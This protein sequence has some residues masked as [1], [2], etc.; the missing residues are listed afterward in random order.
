MAISP[1]VNSFMQQGEQSEGPQDAEQLFRNQFSDLAYN[2]LRAKFPKLLNHVVTLKTMASDMQAG[3]SFG[4]FIIGSGDGLVYVPVAMSDG[5]ITSCE[6]AYDKKTDQFFP[7]DKNTVREIVARNL[8]TEPTLLTKNPRIEDTRAL[9]HNMIRPPSSSNVVLASSRGGVR[10]LPDSCKKAVSDY[11]TRKNPALLGKVAAFYDVEELA[12]KLSPKP[13][14]KTAAGAA[15]LPDFLR[16]DT[17]TKEAANLL[18]DDG[19]KRIL[20][21]GWLITKKAEDASM[22]VAS[23]DKFAKA[24]ETEMRLSLYTPH[25]AGHDFP[26]MEREP[27]K[28]MVQ[29]GNLLL[30]DDRGISFMPAIFCGNIVFY[31]NGRMRLACGQSALVQDLRSDDIDLSSFSMLSPLSGIK[32]KLP[33]DHSWVN[34]MAV[35][36]AR[37]NSWTCLEEVISGLAANFI[38]HDDV[39]RFTGGRGTIQTGDSLASGY[40]MLDNRNFVFPKSARFAPAGS[41]F[42]GKENP[43]PVV[44]SFDALLRLIRGFGFDISTVNDGAAIS[45]TD[46]RSEKTASFR[47]PADAANYLY[48]RYN[49]SGPQIDEVLANKKSTV[50]MKTAYM[51]PTP[52]DVAMIQQG[53]YP[54]GAPEENPMM[55]EMQQQQPPRNF[56]DLDDFAELEDPEMF[57]VGIL[58]AFAQKP[59]IKSLLVEYLPDFLAAED[60]IGR[61]LLLF[62]SQKKEIEDFY[63]PEKAQTVLASCRRIFSILGEMVASLKLYI[64]MG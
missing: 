24:V 38:L 16:L 1:I 20:D 19:K 22:L 48:S 31:R 5:S 64:N 50:F 28:H 43:L 30:C 56:D 18:P 54:Q 59:D 46:S 3:S 12:Y 51:D 7:L 53:Q 11:L 27:R 63:G 52:E 36:P 58:S 32:G 9:F 39:A 34:I 29:G 60:K 62:S 33:D 45:L 41:E 13:I 21:C 57:D 40:L 23:K 17:L 10:D 37:G 42:R 49:M 55:G 47:S 14:E 4:V 44:G 26:F 8:S 15:I 2:A 35:T 25:C 6:M 61:I